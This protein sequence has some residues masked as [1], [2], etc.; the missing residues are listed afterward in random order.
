MSIQ[1]GVLAFIATRCVGFAF[2]FGLAILLSL[3]HVLVESVV[4]RK[5]YQHVASF[6]LGLAF[7]PQGWKPT[8]YIPL[9]SWGFLSFQSSSRASI[10]PSF[11]RQSSDFDSS[12]PT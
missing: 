8:V 10:P 2:H 5:C 6:C 9:A 4:F 1:I 11:L 3:L 12:I 7:D